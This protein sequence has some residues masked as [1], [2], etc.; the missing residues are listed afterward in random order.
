M[1]KETTA[2]LSKNKALSETWKWVKKKQDILILWDICDYLRKINTIKQGVFHYAKRID[3]LSNKANFQ[4][5]HQSKRGK[6]LIRDINHYKDNQ[7]QILE[8]YC[9]IY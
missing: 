4:K 5:V 1:E 7:L 9:K 2:V 6:W 8:L 3:H